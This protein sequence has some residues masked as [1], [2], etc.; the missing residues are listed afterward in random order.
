MVIDMHLA[1]IGP[2]TYT[3]LEWDADMVP[4]QAP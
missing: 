2:V 1:V 4:S 3:Y